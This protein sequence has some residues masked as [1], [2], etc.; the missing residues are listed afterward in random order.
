[1]YYTSKHPKTVFIGCILSKVAT[2]DLKKYF[3]KYGKITGAKTETK[4]LKLASVTFSKV[5]DANKAYQIEGLSEETDDLCMGSRLSPTIEALN[6]DRFKGMWLIETTDARSIT[7]S[8]GR[9]IDTILL[10]HIQTETSSTKKVAETC[11]KK[12][13]R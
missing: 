12:K 5:C 6:M 9:Y 10:E 8:C 3:R 13:P 7:V 11:S 4:K 2:G 1:M